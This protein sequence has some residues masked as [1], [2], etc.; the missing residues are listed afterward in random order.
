MAISHPV[1]QPVGG[2][3]R[4]HP[5]APFIILIVLALLLL[6]ADI[7]R[8]TGLEPLVLDQANSG[9]TFE[10]RPGETVDI[11]L[12]ANLTT[13]YNWQVVPFQATVLAQTGEP[14]VEENEGLLGAP[15]T[16]TFRFT[17]VAP[18]EQ[19]VQLNYVRPWEES[20]VPEDIFMV[21]I[22]VK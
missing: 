2:E 14:V 4:M 21:T 6:L 15:T 10:L 20:A 18:G 5:L 19:V 12:G 3:R 16:V 22:I 13:G 11:S 17:A 9:G 1:P 8:P 7:G